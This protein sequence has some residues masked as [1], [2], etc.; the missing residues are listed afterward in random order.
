MFNVVSI[1]STTG[2]ASSDYLTWGVGAA[3]LF[4]LTLLVL[5]LPDFWRGV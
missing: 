4:F 3:S 5:F 2:Y 1:I